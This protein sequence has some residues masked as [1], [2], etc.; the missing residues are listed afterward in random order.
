MDRNLAVVMIGLVHEACHIHRHFAGYE[1]NGYTKVEE[2]LACINKEKVA[3]RESG[4]SHLLHVV[5]GL[6]SVHCEGD[7]TKHPGCTWVRENCE[8]SADHQITSCPA[9]GRRIQSTTE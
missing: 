5:A 1:Y 2:E 7:L 6:G 8:W 4:L 9:M 3:L